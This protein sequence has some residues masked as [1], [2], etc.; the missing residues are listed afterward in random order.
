MTASP[1]G[2]FPNGFI[3]QLQECRSRGWLRLASRDPLAPPII[4]ERLLSDPAD[5][6]RMVGAV[7]TQL[8]LLAHP[9]FGSLAADVRLG[10]GGDDARRAD[11]DEIARWLLTTAGNGSHISC[12]C[13]MGSADDRAA[14]VAPDGRVYGVDGL[15]VADMS[16]APTVPWSNTNLPAIMIGEH[17]AASW[18]AAWTA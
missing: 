12:T 18:R 7:K 15:F 16:I 9:A 5:L 3:A 13:P 8:E 14:V 10:L 4:V 1:V 11:A 6:R 17:L 2:G